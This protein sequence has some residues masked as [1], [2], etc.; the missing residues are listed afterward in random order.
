MI[1]RSPVS[2]QSLVAMPDW[3]QTLANAISDPAELLYRLGLDKNSLA[4]TES[5]ANGFRLRV[6]EPYL[7]RI[8]KGDAS[9]PLLLQIFP[10]QKETEPTSGYTQD[11][12]DEFSSMPAPGVLHKYHGRILLTLTG[13]CAV[14]C[15][16]CFRRHFPYSDA[17]PT[18]EQWNQTLDYI[19]HNPDIVEV[20][21]SGGDP[22]SVSD[23]RLGEL[24][25]DLD[26]ISHLK[27]LRIHTRLPVVI[28][29]R[30]CKPLTDWLTGTRLQKILVNHINHA[31]EIDDQVNG[32]MQQLSSTGTILLNQSVL[33][34]GVNDRAAT[35]A[36]LSEQL[37]TCGILPYYLHQLDPVQ[38]AA[39]FSVKD[40]IAL[41]LMNKL[42]QCMPGYLVPR[43][44]REQPGKPGKTPLL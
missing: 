6:P 30:V 14:H 42:R 19:R 38:G 1:H 35:L 4:W 17:N 40:E 12:L 10:L 37:F 15:R 39:H 20:I 5:A 31:N 8:H 7:S 34:R 18:N 26:A 41:Q 9:D 32:A 3:Q 25:S 24:V 21:L 23:A 22:L 13:A 28:P 29:S 43:L 44:V 27:R 36:Q 33:L 11:P 16:Y 2:R